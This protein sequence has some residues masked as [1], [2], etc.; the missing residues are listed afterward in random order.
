MSL[1]TLIA[2][3]GSTASVYRPTWGTN[4]DGTGKVAS[5]GTAVLEDLAI[6]LDAVTPEMV[7]KLFGGNE[8]IDARGF[9]D[10]APDIQIEDRLLMTAGGQTGTVFRVESTFPQYHSVPH[11]EL[12]LE[13]TTETIP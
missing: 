5:Y 3:K 11:V 10:G 2:T 7:Q 13:S 12:V 8:V 1:A 9:V 4:A 6:L